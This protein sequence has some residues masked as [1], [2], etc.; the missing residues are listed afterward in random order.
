MLDDFKNSDQQVQPKLKVADFAAKIK[1]KYP[2]YKGV[3]DDVLTQKIIAKY[4]EYNEQVDLEPLKKKDNGSSLSVSSQGTLQSQST[5]PP[6]QGQKEAGNIDLTKQ[7]SVDN[8][9]TGGKSTVWSMSIGTDKGEVLIPRVTPDGKVLSEQ[10]AID[11][12]KK[13]GKHLGVFDSPDNA[14][15]Y[16]EKLHNDYENG[17]IS[18]DN[19]QVKDP[20]QLA[21]E[22]D[23]D[24][25]KTVYGKTMNE[26]GRLK[27]VPDEEAIA[28]S[29]N[30]VK[31]LAD[32]GFNED[33]LQA[34]KDFPQQAFDAPE[35]SKETLTNLYKNNP[36]KFRQLTNE[37][38]VKYAI[39]DAA[40]KD[41]LNNLPD[42]KDKG[43]YASQAGIHA[44]N[45]YSGNERQTPQN[46]QE[47]YAMIQDKQNIINKT[48]SDPEQ[49]QKLHGL[50]QDTYASYIN[51][52]T[53]D[54]KDEYDNSPL[55]SA[56]DINQYAGLKTLELF[57]PEKYKNYL[58]VLKTPIDTKY[59]YTA[60]TSREDVQPF[61]TSDSALAAKNNGKVSEQT[62]NQKIGQQTILS[63]LN[64]IGLNN[65]AKQI[66]STQHDLEQ[67][68]KNAPNDEDKVQIF[69]QFNDTNKR[70][71]DLQNIQ[72]QEDV[73]YPEL[74]ALKFDKQTKEALQQTGQSYLGRESD[75]FGH[76]WSSGVDAVENILTSAFGSEKD[77]ANLFRQRSGESENYNTQTYLPEDYRKRNSPFIYQVSDEL[78]NQLKSVLGDKKLKDA[79]PEEKAQMADIISKN[80]DQIKTITNPEA[81]KTKNFFSKA[82]LT[83]SADFIT[84]VGAFM[85]QVGALKGIGTATK[86][87]EAAT[88]FK[89][90]YAG[91]FDKS[92]AEG[93]S[94]DAA[95]SIGMLD[96]AVSSAM[97]LF[98]SKYEDMQ[99]ALS[100]GRSRMAKQLAGLSESAWDSLVEKNKSLASRIGGS[101][102]N[103][104]IE[105]TKNAVKFGGVAP[106]LH[107]V[108]HNT[109]L[110]ENKPVEDIISEAAGSTM[111]MMRGSLG[112]AAIGAVTG[113]MKYKAS[114]LEKS[115][116]W[117]LGDNSEIG[118]AKIDE[119]V[120]KGDLS[121]DAGDVRKKAIDNISKLVK[122]VPTENDKGKQLTDTERQDYLYN[123]AIKDKA[124]E[125]AKDLPE[126]QAEKHDME[127]QIAEHRNAIILTNPSDKQL[128]ARKAQLEKSL[129]PEK[130]AE[131]KNI[132][133]PQK[134]IIAAKA[135]I[136]AIDEHLEESSKVKANVQ[137]PVTMPKNIEIGHDADIARANEN[138]VT[139][140]PPT[141]VPEPITPKENVVVVNA[142]AIKN[143]IY[144][145]LAKDPE[146]T[147]TLLKE[148]SDQWHDERSRAK[149][150]TDFPPAIIEAAKK[151]YPQE[152][153]AGL[154]I[155]EGGKK[156]GI[157]NKVSNEVRSE[158]QLPKVEVPKLGKDNEVIQEGKRLVDEGEINPHEVVQ[159][160]LDT[161]QG[162]HPKE[163][164]AMQYYMHQLSAHETD[165]R[166][167]LSEASAP[168]DKAT[169]SGK[170]QQL[171]D[172][173]DA[174]T[175]A[176][177]IAGKAWSDVGNIRQ[178][179]IDD[180][181][182]PSRE[183]AIIKDAYGG[184]IPK[185]VQERLDKLTT[186]RDTAI[187]ERQKVEEQ[188]RHKMAA[189]GF[190]EIKKQATRQSKNKEDK[191]KLKEEEQKLLDE[192]KKAFKK[193]LGNLNAG[194]PIPKAT[195]EALGKLSVN[196]FKQGVNGLEA[197]VDKI[198]ENLKDDVAGLSKKDI[199]NAIANYEPLQEQQEIKRLNKKADLIEDKV[200]P[201]SIKTTG[202][203]FSPSEPTDF[204]KP[205]KVEKQ[206]RSSTEWVR[207]NQRV[208][209]AEFKMKVEKRK[210]FES[211]KNWYQKGLAWAG[212]LTRLSV[213]SGYNVLGKLAA[214][215][216]VGAAGK[217]PLE[218]IVGGVYSQIFKGIAQKAPIEGFLNARAEAKWYKEFFNPKKFVHNSWEIL[219]TGS[220][221][222]GKRL[223][224]A[225]YEHV[226]F[227]YIPT[228]LHQIIKDPV[229]RG[230]FEA[231][232]LNGMVWAEKNGLD[233]QDPLVINSIENAAYK[234]A[235]Y[236][237]FQEQNWL[238]KK[239]TSYKSKL[240]KAGNLGATAKFL[241]DFMIPV[242]TVPTNIVRRLITTSPFGLIRGSKE[243]IQAYRNGIE[244]LKP[245]E[246][247]H[248]M[249][250]LKQGS[251]GTA[252]WLIGWFGASSFGGLYS[253]YNPNKKR[254]EGELASDEMSVGGKMIPKPVQHALP[255]EVIQ[256]AA[257]ARH[258]FDNYVSHKHE[259]TPQSIYAAGM[260]S[261]GAL[262][263]QIPVI[264]TGVHA[265]EA[266]GNPYEAEKFK[267]DVKRRFEPQI[268]RE[269]G[270]IPKEQKKHK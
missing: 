195:L 248:V 20:F 223:G 193:D 153:N 107:D 257:T 87:A 57:D 159:R 76:S 178:I 185:E 137:E 179:L 269:T 196:Y 3:P 239:F 265:V 83:E 79:T 251:L 190:E 143:P 249:Q 259:S 17:K 36:E 247:D 268:L 243:V 214:A 204:L 129:I 99:S 62:I 234:R 19:S 154:N 68:Y 264:E 192:L 2:E 102:K 256:F 211:Q 191:A 224:S 86:L 135:E 226:P 49:K 198:Y 170:L 199:R 116:V 167:Q 42:D 125:T 30:T 194:I 184:E 176:N 161:K 9:Y 175:S 16:A 220:S 1:A 119:A 33:F 141:K 139:I 78:K 157:K 35:T 15:T 18:T 244:K 134:E 50:L 172:N 221:D 10:E 75:R 201:P 136:K 14:N 66:R 149:A 262:L 188:L 263:E 108:A 245:E 84:D 177:I 126:R 232:F 40:E 174:A 117:D 12:Y 11:N 8:P 208:A 227:L 28:R 69:N 13:T 146:N 166:E 32:K 26:L 113:A 152:E 73:K 61:V 52:Q 233:I 147:D 114:P 44:G 230:T 91:S 122:K 58:N 6:T 70:L 115:A 171:S 148:V 43:Y 187:A 97:A 54:F 24:S 89:D 124:N 31:G 110:N 212:R 21:Q 65:E 121:V 111:D 237:I 128:E 222:L 206:F 183:K 112:L 254:K 160:V 132:E 267:E 118:K 202:N 156:T 165:L 7:P 210:A 169:V 162:M 209:N 56:L 46:M 82:T 145:D 23:A 63:E 5:N 219:K 164:M 94:V 90:G 229:K 203:K 266:T 109:F 47:V 67:A 151:A 72:K 261:I 252:L 173:I 98:G 186:E 100:G 207:A 22:A 131:G 255:L 103:S 217:R 53:A 92:I 238:S 205:S 51:P 260:A 189:Q 38:K 34:V 253:K 197:M 81:G 74:A 181:F 180:A 213:L 140:E 155:E 235:Q 64:N 80:Q 27:D 142:D 163:A 168:E 93:K 270:I 85:S 45:L 77:K 95:H 250:Q 241:T 88:L 60:N 71:T 228:D 133:I 240:E 246:A 258:V 218:Q 105:T 138:G 150:E 231:S 48:I 236:E 200:T 39:Q 29:K 216:T 25:K 101:L 144:R 37:A 215:A 120:T 59:Y 242:S 225:E 41:A 104:A 182:K 130:D 106:I 96:G 127:A 55:K 158:M 4:P 123:L